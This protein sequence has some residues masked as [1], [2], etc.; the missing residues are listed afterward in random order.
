MIKIKQKTGVAK[1]GNESKEMVRCALSIPNLKTALDMGCGN[2]F[3]AISLAKNGV[4][5]SGVD[6][7]SDAIA[8]SKLNANLNEVSA[9]FFESNVFSNVDDKYQLI[10]F[11]FPVGNIGGSA[12]IDKIKSKMPKGTFLTKIAFILSK[13]SRWKL[14]TRFFNEVLSYLEENGQVVLY[15]HKSEVKSLKKHYTSFNFELFKLHSTGLGVFRV[16]F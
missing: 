6:I 13:K 11:N 10:L 4:E 3:I 16:T 8:L 9:I 14:I 2:G 1:H 7:S 15:L 5:V 12:F